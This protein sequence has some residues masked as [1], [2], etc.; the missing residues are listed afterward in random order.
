MGA[1]NKVHKFSGGRLIVSPSNLA[2]PSTDCDGTQ[3]GTCQNLHLRGTVKL[4][5]I[6]AEE[7]GSATVDGVL[8]DPE[9]ILQGTFTGW[10]EDFAATWFYGGSTGSGTPTVT[11]AEG[12]YGKLATAERGRTILWLPKDDAADPALICYNAIPWRMPKPLYFSGR[13]PAVVHASWLL[14]RD[15]NN[16]VWK[17]AL[18]ASL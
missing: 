5:P 1:T 13:K 14:L 12:S 7:W 4:D 11:A 2:S 8:L 9:W 16:L 15:S 17:S 18:L 6:T 3:L 10:D